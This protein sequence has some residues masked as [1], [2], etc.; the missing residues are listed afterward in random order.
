LNNPYE[1]TE[2]DV[3]D[4]LGYTGGTSNVSDDD[5]EREECEV[6]PIPSYS[7]LQYRFGTIRRYMEPHSC[8][9]SKYVG[10]LVQLEK[11]LQV[12]HA[13]ESHQ[14]TIDSYFTCDL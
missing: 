7:N 6:E 4:V 3:W 5:C 11:Y 13:D 2:E 1:V 14:R 9:V 12:M 8:D 10:L